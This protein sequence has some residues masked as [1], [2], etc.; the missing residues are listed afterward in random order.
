MG[1]TRFRLAPL[2]K[3]LIA[4]LACIALSFVALAGCTQQQADEGP[5]YQ[6]EAFLT[7]LG[8]G[9]DARWDLTAAHDQAHPNEDATA[10][11]MKSYIQ[12]ELD[13]IEKYSNA[14]FEDT[15]LHELAISYINALKKTSEAAE[16]Y[17]ASNYD[18][19]E[20]WSEAY[21]ERVMV[22]KE[23]LENYN[24]VTSDRHKD[25]RDEVMSDAK[26]AQSAADAKAAM[27]SLADTMVF[28]FTDSGYGTITGSATVANTTEYDF[29]SASFDVQLYDEA[30]VRI[31]T[32][33]AS[34]E[35][36][37]AGESVVFEIYV[38]SEKIPATV[39]VVPSYYEVA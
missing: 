17:N 20:E 39:K 1:A 8:K 22:L 5:D 28:S 29:K 18:S 25:T 3:K 23:I 27:Q 34:T 16:S 32:D 37:T 12:A 31:E 7:D 21:N 4:L 24:V 14:T 6:D 30:G 26:Y 35:N 15:K 33:Y 36:W 10:S 13:A 2:S 19:L 38:S 9:L 11:D